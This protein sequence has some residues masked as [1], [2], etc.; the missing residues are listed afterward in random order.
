MT[1]AQGLYP[2]SCHV[3]VLSPQGS[4]WKSIFLQSSPA[5]RGHCTSLGP[6]EQ[7]RNAACLSP[8]VLFKG[9]APRFHPACVLGRKKKFLCS[10]PKCHGVCLC[11]PLCENSVWCCSPSCS[12]QSSKLPGV[13]APSSWSSPWFVQHAQFSCSWSLQTSDFTHRSHFST[14]AFESPRT[15]YTVV[16]LRPSGLSFLPAPK[17]C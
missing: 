12:H 17:G 2:D 11:S 3:F 16:Q 10:L 6:A 5:S 14:I 8:P 4:N 15:R 7:R 13:P 9:W 1:G